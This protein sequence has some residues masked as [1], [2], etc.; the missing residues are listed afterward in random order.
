MHFVVGQTSHAVAGPEVLFNGE[1][2]APFTVVEADTETGKIIRIGWDAEGHAILDDTGE[3]VE[4][5]QYGRVEFRKVA[6]DA[7][8][9]ASAPSAYAC[10]P[11]PVR[12]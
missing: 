1:P 2:C 8:P 5:T 10:A 7:S 11:S 9:E 6:S 4:T 12:R 3:P